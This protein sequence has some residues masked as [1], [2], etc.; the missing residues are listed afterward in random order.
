MPAPQYRW[1]DQAAE[2]PVVRPYALIGGRVRPSGAVID[3]LA[4][5][6]AVD[7]APGVAMFA[8]PEYAHVIRLCGQ[9]T[10]VADLAADL[11]LPLGVVRIVL[12]DMRERGL[13]VI[14]QPRTT[15][16]TDARVL[17]DVADALRKL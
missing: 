14:R 11:D 9:P 10:P 8:E 16:L 15:P 2:G 7:N 5:V 13:I 1:L 4:I 6:Q 3:L 12:S 17:K